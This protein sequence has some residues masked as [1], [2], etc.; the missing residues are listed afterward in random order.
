MKPSGEIVRSNKLGRLVY[1]SR[2]CSAI[3]SNKPRRAKEIV[4]K[5][6]VCNKDFVSSTKTKASTFCSRSC[7]S[8]G[9]MTEYRLEKAKISGFINASNLISAAEALKRREAWKY[10]ILEQVLKARPHEFEYPL[11]GYVFDLALF[12]TKVLVEFD[13]DYHKSG[14]QVGVDAI[15]NEVAKKAGFMIIRREVVDTK[16]LGVETIEGL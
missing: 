1:C 2:S 3:A 7:A 14:K 16:V 4:K 11:D 13:G 6:P 5:C 15:K 8:K 12:D 9:S 10:V